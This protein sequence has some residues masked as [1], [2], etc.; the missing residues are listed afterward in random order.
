VPMDYNANGYL[1]RRTASES[2]VHVKDGTL[3]DLVN[4]V[5]EKMTGHMP[6]SKSRSE[7]RSISDR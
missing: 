4:Y 1:E 7:K 3:K 5:M 6:S 2:Y